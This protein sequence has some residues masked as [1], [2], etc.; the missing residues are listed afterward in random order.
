MSTTEKV[1]RLEEDGLV[2]LAGNNVP[3]LPT[4]YD[5]I[6]EQGNVLYLDEERLR[7]KE[8]PDK[9]L[10]KN[11]SNG[12]GIKNFLVTHLLARDWN[13]SLIL[14]LFRKLLAW[15][16]FMQHPETMQ[17]KL[18]KRG[19]YFE[20]QDSTY[21][22][23]SIY[24]LNVDADENLPGTAGYNEKVRK[25]HAPHSGGAFACKE[26][27]SGASK[28]IPMEKTISTDVERDFRSV[29]VPMDLVKRAI[30]EAQYIGGMKECLCRAGNN[31]QTYPHDVACLFLNMGGKVV[32]DHG[33]AVEL[34][35]E[36]AYERVDKAA[37]LG[38][39]C[40]SLWVEVEQLIWGF[41]ND[42]MDA[43]LEVCFCCPCCCVGF[44]LSK[45]ATR[46]VKHRFSPSG[47][48]AVVNHDICV[49]CGECLGD[50][51]PQDAIHFRK[52]DGKMV[53]DQENCVGC[54]FCRA[55]CSAGAVSIKQTMPMRESMHEYMLKEGR[56][57]I[58]PGGE[59]EHGPLT[60]PLEAATMNMANVAA[61][62]ISAVGKTASSV[63]RGTD[64][65]PDAVT[66]KIEE[67]TDIAEGIKQD[68]KEKKTS[69]G[70]DAQ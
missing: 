24:N 59:F 20:P 22:T 67:A 48:T 21:S 4:S 19:M 65:V 53:V 52:R 29:T 46:D 10:F 40:Q 45:N 15:S 58:V 50:Y 37:E 27:V 56:L 7:R 34:T 57:N 33:M 69:E 63:A 64:R 42:Q 26:Q 11:H 28:T 17:S 18:Y 43:F 60:K 39:V 1:S 13:W 25:G 41:R 55:H 16:R 38:L 49:G 12:L 14:A 8:Q 66:D 5:N 44:N 6:D 9:P 68:I 51:C 54:G 2:D 30:D 23:G 61:H 35:K 31:C 47:W 32:V 36:E 62:S 70:E 3:D